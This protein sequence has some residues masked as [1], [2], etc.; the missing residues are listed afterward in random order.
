M[1]LEPRHFLVLGSQST[2]PIKAIQELAR[3][4]TAPCRLMVVTSPRTQPFSYRSKTR[5][6]ALS[7]LSRA[8]RPGLPIP[9]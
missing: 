1:A 7:I 3:H 5:L 6:A 4:K 9:A 2:A 8:K